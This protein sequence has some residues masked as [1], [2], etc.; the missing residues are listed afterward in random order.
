VK[1]KGHVKRHTEVKHNNIQNKMS[2]NIALNGIN[3]VKPGK[4][5][6]L[7]G[8]NIVVEEENVAKYGQIECPIYKTN[9]ISQ[10]NFHCGHIIAEKIGGVTTIEKPK[11]HL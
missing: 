2:E 1:N 5:I 4:N 9:T 3:V 10:F 11:I 6:A 7:N 8:E